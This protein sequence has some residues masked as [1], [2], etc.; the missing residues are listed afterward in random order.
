[1]SAATDY[2]DK[3]QELLARLRAT[4]LPA[5]ERAAEICADRIHRAD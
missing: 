2:F 3:T 1:M 5:I 4:Q